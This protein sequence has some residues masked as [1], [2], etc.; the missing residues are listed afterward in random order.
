MR[1]PGQFS[2]RII[3]CTSEV[4]LVSKENVKISYY[5]AKENQVT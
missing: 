2:I 1:K 4:I 3:S 5:R